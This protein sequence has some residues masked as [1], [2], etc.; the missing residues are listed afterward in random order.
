M[1]QVVAFGWWAASLG[2][3]VL[4]GCQ[5][6]TFADGLPNRLDCSGCHGG[7]E[8]AAPP[9]AVRGDTSTTNLAVGAHQAHLRKGDLGKP[10]LCEACHVVPTV[11]DGTTHPDPQGR[12]A[13]VVF[14][15]LARADQA[16]PTWDRARGECSNTYC[17]GGTLRGAGSRQAPVWTR[18]DGSQN[19]CV[20]C[21]GNPP[22][23]GHP[24]DSKCETCHG[25][26]VNQD[27]V[28]IN[29]A[30]HVDGLIQVGGGGNADG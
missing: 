15:G 21:H 5:R 6:T 16:I 12:P 23:D 2:L 30:L 10:V 8:N 29:P 17:H 22:A 28:I 9:R 11:M 7:S 13:P 1:G 4:S 14:A 3:L 27:G 18:V 25:D 20:S 26:V 24:D 19:K